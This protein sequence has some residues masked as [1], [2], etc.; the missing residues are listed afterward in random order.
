MVVLENSDI[1]SNSITAKGFW[2]IEH[3]SDMALMGGVTLPQKGTLL[4]IGANVG[5]YSLL[6]AHHG[7]RVIAVEPMTRNRRAI[8]A[9]LCLNPDLKRYVTVIAAALVAPEEVALTHCVIRSSNETTNIGNGILTCGSSDEVKLC[10]GGDDNCEVVPVETLDTALAKANPASVDVV[11]MDV[12]SYEC[13]VFAGGH[14]LFEKYHPKLLQVETEW[15]R[16][17]ECVQAK[18]AKFAYRTVTHGPD[19]TMVLLSPSIA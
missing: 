19:T 2:E 7:Y 15:G 11:K 12:E 4:D 3:P 5:Y 13:N 17:M 10:I 9:S 16:G 18:A 8:E 1:V 6:F 14:T